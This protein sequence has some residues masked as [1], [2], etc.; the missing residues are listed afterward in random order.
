[1]LASFE[2]VVLMVVGADSALVA[3]RRR[4]ILIAV[5]FL[6]LLS[7]MSRCA[8]PILGLSPDAR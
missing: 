2:F 6:V 8:L 3:K 4:D 5:H 1:M 7:V